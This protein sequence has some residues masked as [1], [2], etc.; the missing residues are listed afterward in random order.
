MPEHEVS[1]TQEELKPYEPPE[2]LHEM[3]LETRAGSPMR[4]GFPDPTNPLP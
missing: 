2:I 3:D 4:P 1:Q